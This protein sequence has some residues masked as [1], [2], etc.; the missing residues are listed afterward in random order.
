MLDTSNARLERLFDFL[1]RELPA[2][3]NGFANNLM[4][5]LSTASESEG[6]SR[7]LLDLCEDRF[8]RL[9]ADNLPAVPFDIRA[10]SHISFM[11]F[12]GFAIGRNLPAGEGETLRAARTFAALLAGDRTP[13][14]E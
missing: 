10:L 13:S 1:W 11:A 7:H 14:P 5:A 8:A 3:R 6:Y 9:L 4:Q 12:D 2:D